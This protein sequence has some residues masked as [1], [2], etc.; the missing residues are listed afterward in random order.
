MVNEY[1]TTSGSS[2]R[3]GADGSLRIG[4]HAWMASRA[5]D[6]MGFI[7]ERTSSENSISKR[8]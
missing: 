6:P 5:L 2:F 4:R 8:N 3:L 1:G 7:R